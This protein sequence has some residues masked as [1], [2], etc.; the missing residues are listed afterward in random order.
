M[1]SAQEIRVETG[2]LLRNCHPA[3][4]RK[5]KE[6]VHLLQT[7]HTTSGALPASYS[8]DTRAPFLSVKRE[9][10]LGMSGTIPLLPPM[11][12]WRQAN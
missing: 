8:M 10:S 11:L 7:A 1:S 2:W 4:D 5:A 12:Y 6:W 3:T 9:A